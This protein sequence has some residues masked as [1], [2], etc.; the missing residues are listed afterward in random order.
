MQQFKSDFS[1]IAIH[2]INK[3]GCDYKKATWPE[4]VDYE[5]H[6][7]FDGKSNGPIYYSRTT[8]GDK[9]TQYCKIEKN[10]KNEIV[11]LPGDGWNFM[12]RR[13]TT[14]NKKTEDDDANVPHEMMC[15]ICFDK[16]II[17]AVK[18]CGHASMCAVCAKEIYKTK[19]EC[20]ICKKKMINEPIKLFFA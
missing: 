8:F 18:E 13:D 11:V 3:P 6:D 10:K 5:V 15:K 19:A 7:I 14:N 9:K 1:L 20:P 16:K 12:V 2:E 4:D 17:Y